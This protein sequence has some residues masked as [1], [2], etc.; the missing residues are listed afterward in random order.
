M[1]SHRERVWVNFDGLVTLIEE[2][3]S[4]EFEYYCGYKNPQEKLLKVILS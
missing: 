2:V 3:I 4:K 1:L